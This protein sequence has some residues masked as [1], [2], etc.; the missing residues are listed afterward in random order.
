MDRTR[1][2]DGSNPTI[3]YPSIQQHPYVRTYSTHTLS[4]PSAAGAG[5]GGVQGEAPVAAAASVLL[6][7]VV[8]AISWKLWVAVDRA[9][10]VRRMGMPRVPGGL[11]YIGQVPALT[12]SPP[13]DLMVRWM[14]ELGPI[15][16]FTLFGEECVVAADPGLLKVVLQ[17]S[18]KAFKKD[19]DFTYKPFMPLLGTGLVTSEGQL[20][21]TQRAMVSAVFRIEILEIIP[22]IAK[23][24]VG[25]WVFFGGVVDAG[26]NVLDESI[27]LTLVASSHHPHPSTDL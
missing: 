3:Y 13:W 19:L 21:Y 14:K 20:W 5:G 11:P 6:G 9:V 2:I 8:V 12:Q 16:R 25:C 18:M 4:L 15:Y 27:Q 10:K 26:G 1:W 22:H 24:C 17:S 23:R 7:V